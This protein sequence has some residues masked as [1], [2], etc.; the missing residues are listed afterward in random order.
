MGRDAAL[1]R[2]RFSAMRQSNQ[3]FEA[4]NV[5]VETRILIYCL[6]AKGATLKPPAILALVLSLTVQFN[7]TASEPD[8]DYVVTGCGGFP[9]TSELTSMWLVRSD[10]KPVVMVYF[11][12]PDGWHNTEWKSHFD[13][14]L[15]RLDTKTQ[16]KPAWAEFTSEKVTLRTWLDPKT[17]QVQV[18][19]SKFSIQEANTFLV[20]HITDP[21]QQK[22]IPLGRFDLPPSG[23]EPAALAFLHAND[24][25]DSQIRKKIAAAGN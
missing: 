25:V 14:N 17:H 19:K 9:I 24:R 4:K 18:Q 2:P 10:G 11:H 23:A 7:S 8:E 15:V 6:R 13:L 12:G 21:Q 1:R 5:R 3:K 22:V 16:P 20:I